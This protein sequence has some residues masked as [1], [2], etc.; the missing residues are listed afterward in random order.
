MGIL[1]QK[2]YSKDMEKERK[3]LMKQEIIDQIRGC[4]FGG[5][6]GDALGYPVEFMG[7]KEIFS[8]Y[9]EKGIT[10]YELNPK[11]GKAL[12]SDDTQM[13][14]F[15]ANGILAGEA[16]TRTGGDAGPFRIYVEKAYQDWLI[17]QKVSFEQYQKSPS[18]ASKRA[19]WLMDVPELFARRA[20]GITCLDALSK[21][22]I[23]KPEIQ[24]YI[25][26]PQNSSKGCGGV[27]RVAP[28]GLLRTSSIEKLDY[29]GAQLAA[30]THGHSLGYMTGAVLTHV[31]NRIVYPEPEQE[32]V[33]EKK[34]LKKI[35]LEA[36]DKTEEIFQGDP[37]LKYLT[38]LIELAVD[39]SENDQDDLQNIH[40]LGEGWVAE[41][42]LA[43]A[44]YC[45]LRYQKDFSAGIIASVNHK[46]DS[47][48][49]G[50][51]TGNILGA[52]LGY[53]RIED[54]WKR[55]LELSEIILE[56]AGDISQVCEINEYGV[57]GQDPD[58]KRK[59]ISCRREADQI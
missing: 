32:D 8:H 51:V 36:R 48:S 37:Y 31:I 16:R 17:T 2:I 1:T 45:S 9:G 5:A 44:L 43:I 47:D 50:A 12:I 46:G 56:M 23:K 54:K 57:P 24:D 4:L 33:S 30:I 53:E 15:T 14:L 28:A 6:A 59:Y 22:Y 55:D 38:E 25:A 27:M 40:R 42:T 10:Q 26:S 34:S 19:A 18:F 21:L 41:E 58:W 20:P 52:W 35:V 11:L 7:E 39:L 49:T 13:T 3:I 29:E